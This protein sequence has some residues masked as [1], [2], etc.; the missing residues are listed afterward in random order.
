MLLG[1]PRPPLLQSVQTVEIVGALVLET[2]ENITVL[3]SSNSLANFD[4][5]YF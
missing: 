2:I 1:L 5:T 3:D 4:T